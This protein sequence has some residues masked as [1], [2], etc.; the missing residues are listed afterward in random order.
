MSFNEVMALIMPSIIACLFYSKVTN[1]AL[2]LFEIIG[3]IVFFMLTTNCICYATLIF[4]RKTIIFEYTPTFTL[5]YCLT[6]TFI[7]LLMAIL[8]IFIELNLKI[9]FKVESTDE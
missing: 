7:A 5:K 3:K 9:R 8:Y 2:P 1:R 6:A 4:L